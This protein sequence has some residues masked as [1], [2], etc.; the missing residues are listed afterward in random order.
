MHGWRKAREAAL[1]FALACPALCGDEPEAWL[2]PAVELAA[3]DMAKPV[4][5]DVRA[6]ALL[7]AVR[8]DGSAAWRLGPDVPAPDARGWHA[9]ATPADLGQS[10]RPRHVVVLPDRRACAAALFRVLQELESLELRSVWIAARDGEAR[11]GVLAAGLPG[12]RRDSGAAP[13]AIAVTV[14]A[15]AKPGLAAADL[16][17]EFYRIWK[18]VEA[19]KGRWRVEIRPAADQPAAA[20][21]AVLNEARRFGAPVSVA[22]AD[23]GMPDVA[24]AATVYRVWPRAAALRSQNGARAADLEVPALRPGVPLA[25]DPLANPVPAPVAAEPAAS[26]GTPARPADVSRARSSR[27]TP[28]AQA[29]VRRALSW[30]IEH[31]DPGSGA[32]SCAEFGAECGCTGAGSAENDV[33]VTALALQALLFAAPLGLGA[34]ADAATERGIGFLLARQDPKSGAFGDSRVGTSFVYCHAAAT[35][36]LLK[37]SER[38]GAAETLEPAI[39]R[40]L[41]LIHGARNPYGAWRYGATPSGTSDVSVTGWMV[42]ALCLARERGFEVEAAALQ[43]ALRFIDAMTDEGGRTGYTQQ[44]SES[45]RTPERLERWPGAKS[46]AMTA[47]ALASRLCVDRSA[48]SSDVVRSGL[49][50]LRKRPPLWDETEGTIDFYYW[51]RAALAMQLAG[52]SHGDYWNGALCDAVIGKQR[53]GGCA[54]GSWDP[55]V[56]VWGEDGGRVYA[57]AVLALALLAP[58]AAGAKVR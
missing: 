44:G 13:L 14:D 54:A 32:W 45:A 48:A 57:T 38:A 52:R 43:D 41:R 9:L 19:G 2:D 11:L 42:E 29:A 17:P 21:V 24:A 7:V 26:A 53:R 40:A 27:L 49:E 10:L 16:Y 37:A 18:T 33:G 31:Q 4:P 20:V 3:A 23:A 15:G 5:A 56:E 58:D 22:V 34:D 8:A 28:S 25:G 30:L 35:L 47:T 6:G 36:A 1:G 50:L 39:E 46:E 51:S 55:Q 12:E